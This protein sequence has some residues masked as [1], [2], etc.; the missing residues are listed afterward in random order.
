[1]GVGRKEKAT[2]PTPPSAP[3]GGYWEKEPTEDE[4]LFSVFIDI[5]CLTFMI[6]RFYLGVLAGPRS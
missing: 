2:P 1:M 5:L 4:K 3:R 6:F